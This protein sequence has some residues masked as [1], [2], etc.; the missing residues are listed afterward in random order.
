MLGFPGFDG[1]LDGFGLAALN[2]KQQAVS[3]D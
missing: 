1:F 3:H 2:A